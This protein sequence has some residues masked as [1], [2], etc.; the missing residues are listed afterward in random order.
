MRVQNTAK[1][2]LLGILIVPLSPIKVVE[3]FASLG[4]ME[5]G[6]VPVEQIVVPAGGA[7]LLRPYA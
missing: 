5:L 3:F 6:V 4:D 1:D 2:C 7:T